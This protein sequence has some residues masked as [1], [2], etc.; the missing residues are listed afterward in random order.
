MYSMRQM[1]RQSTRRLNMNIK[2]VSCSYK[3]AKT[4]T[5]QELYPY[6]DY[7][8]AESEAKE[9]T[10]AGKKVIAVPDEH[11]AN[12]T[13]RVRNYVLNNILPKHDCVIFMDDDYD[14]FYR[15]QN[16]TKVLMGQKE[17]EE[18]CEQMSL[19][20]KE[21]GYWMW[22]V[23]CVGD[24]GA[25]REHT[26]FSTQ[27]YISS[28]F[29]AHLNG[30]RQR[31]DDKLPLKEDYD[32]TLQHIVFKGGCLRANFCHYDVKQAEQAGGCATYR[33]LEKERSQF[34]AFQKKWGKDI[35]QRDYKSRRSFDFNPIIKSPRRGV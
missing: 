5:T 18:F 28:T 11:G 12:G 33:N 2:Y 7:V 1:M 21:W 30:T 16:Q 31:Y 13:S 32:M 8:V 14:A 27:N 29:N 15:W 3:R 34:E 26:P 35:V 9:Y 10:D 22:G 20:C 4:C 19:L 23:N 24:K 17:L 6:V 25:Y